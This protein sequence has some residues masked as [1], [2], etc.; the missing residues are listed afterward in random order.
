MTASTAAQRNKQAVRRWADEIIDQ[1]RL[2]VA[3]EIFTPELV[4]PA[5]QC[6]APFR[7]S[8]PDVEM[9]VVSLIA[10]GHQVAGRFT[11]SG[12]HAGPWLGHPPTGRRF[13]NIDEVYFFSFSQ[14]K[15]AAYWGLE[16]T[17]K[18]LKQLGLA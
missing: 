15:I 8:F 5:Q 16:D 13:D 6:V 14:A 3:E 2:E 9:R 12:T 7:R 18:R 4:G 1:G 10:E 17:R 11:C